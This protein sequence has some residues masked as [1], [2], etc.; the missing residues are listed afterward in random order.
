MPLAPNNHTYLQM[1]G[2]CYIHLDAQACQRVY[3]DY[4]LL[5]EGSALLLLF[6]SPYREEL[7]KWMERYNTLHNQCGS[8]WDL[9]FSLLEKRTDQAD[10]TSL[11]P[12]CTSLPV[13]LKPFFMYNFWAAICT[14]EVSRCSL[15]YPRASALVSSSSRIICPKPRP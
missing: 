1:A 15:V 9:Y 5:D 2:V 8:P 6:H 11:S 13:S 12:R 14:T 10:S 7:M 4:P 3:S